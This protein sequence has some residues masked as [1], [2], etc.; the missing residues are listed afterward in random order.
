MKNGWL[1]GNGFYHSGSFDSL[2]ASLIQEAQALDVSLTLMF[3]DGLCPFPD[4]KKE[5]PPDFVL[6]WD[7]DICLAAQLEK[8]DIPVFN[9]S[10]SIALCDDKTLTYVTLS[11]VVPMPETILA[12]TA[13][14]GYGD[15][16]FLSRVEQ[17]LSFPYVFKEGYGSFGRQVF[18]IHDREEGL[19]H[20]NALDGKPALFQ[21]F[22]SS[23]AGRDVRVYVC[24]G[25][26]V[27]AME[28]IAPAGDFRANIMNGGTGRLHVLSKEEEEISLKSVAA[29]DLTF[30]GVDLLFSPEGPLLCEV[31]SNAHFAGLCKASGVNIPREILLSVLSA[32]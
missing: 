1:I 14:Y 9:S 25:R 17:K 28:R 10:R 29:L 13:Y 6:F 30:G 3:N 7:K 18:L 19:A 20:L 4:L 24:G 11:G 12:P 2:Y 26:C 27:A 16:S 21:R 5:P 8:A 15:A 31:N 23:S 32:L 22:V